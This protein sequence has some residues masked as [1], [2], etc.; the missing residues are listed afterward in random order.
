LSFYGLQLGLAFWTNNLWQLVT[1]LGTVGLLAL[2]VVPREER[3][4]EARLPA[5]YLPYKASVRRWL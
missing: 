4:L 5:T 1:L 3:Y 2:V